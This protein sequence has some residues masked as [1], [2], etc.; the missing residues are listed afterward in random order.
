MLNQI[1]TAGLV[2]SF[3]VGGLVQGKNASTTR[4]RALEI[5]K[6]DPVVREYLGQANTT[7]KPLEAMLYSVDCGFTGCSERYLVGQ[8]ANNHADAPSAILLARVTVPVGTSP[9]PAKLEIVKVK[10]VVQDE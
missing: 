9:V 7:F 2:L 3:T 4:E 6:T 10:P 8:V 1:L 5:Y